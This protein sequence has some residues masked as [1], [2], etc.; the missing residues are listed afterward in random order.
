MKTVFQTVSEHKCMGCG[1]CAAVCHFGAIQMADNKDGF[2]N[3]VI[4]KSLCKECMKCFNI[5]PAQNPTYP[6][7][8]EPL[9]YAAMAKD[10]IRKISSS[11]GV[12]TVLAEFIINMDGYVCGAAFNDDFSVSHIIVNEIE[13]LDRL[14]GSKY[15]QSDTNNT[16]AKTKELLDQNKY[17]LYTGTPCQIAG[18]YAYLQHDYPHLFTVDLVC[19]GITSSKVFRKYHKDCHNGK[20]ITH[21]GFKE[22]E[23]WGW[24]AGMKLSFDDGSEYAAIAQ[25]DPFFNAYLK[26]LAKN[27]ACEFCTSNAIPRQADL[28]IGDFWGIR[29]ADPSLDDNKGTSVVLI[30]NEKGSELFNNVKDRFKLVRQVDLSYAIAGNHSLVKPYRVHKN[31]KWFFRRLE[32]EVFDKLENKCENSKYDVGIVGVWYGLNYGSI[33]TYYALNRI[34]EN[35]GYDCL[36]VN[37]PSMLWNDR[38]IDPNTIS[39]KFIGKYCNISEPTNNEEELKKINDMCDMFV[40]GSDVIWNYDICGKQSGHYFFLDFVDPEKKKIAYA[41]SFGTGYSAPPEHKEKTEFLLRSFDAISAREINGIEL[42]KSNFNITAEQVI[43]PVFLN[44][45]QDYEKLAET[46]NINDNAE[47]L[48]SYFLGPEIRKK[49]M[50]ELICSELGLEYRNLTNP[51]KPL[52]VQEGKL[53]LPLLR[54][55]TV[56]KWL[57]YFKNCKYYIGDSFHGMCFAIIFRKPF[58]VYV[59]KGAK[60]NCRFESLLNILGIKNR[61]VYIE[62]NETMKAG[63]LKLLNEPID[64]DEA[65]RR[66]EVEKGKSYNWLRDNLKA[67]KKQNYEYKQ[68]DGLPGNLI[69]IYYCAKT[70]FMNRKNRKVIMWGEHEPT[71]RILKKYFNIDVEFVVVRNKS[72]VN[73]TTFFDI[74]TIKGKQNEYYVVVPFNKYNEHDMQMFNNFGF[75]YISDV[76]YR[77]IKPIVLKDR[78]Y[79]NNSY[80][81]QFGNVIK[82]NLGNVNT[83][84]INGCNNK[85]IIHNKVNRP[86]SIFTVNV[87]SNCKINIGDN[88]SFSSKTNILLYGIA[89]SELVIENGIKSADLD[90]RIWSDVAKSSVLIREGCTFGS[91]NTLSCCAGKKLVVGKDCMFSYNIT[92]QCGDGHSIFDVTTGKNVNSIVENQLP[93]A[94]MLVLGE[95]VWIGRNAVIMHGSNIG[96]GSIVGAQSFVK[97]CFPNNCAIGG[98]PAKIVKKNIAWSRNNCSSNILDCGEKYI[99]ETADLPSLTGKNVLVLGGT[100]FMGIRLVEKLLRE[101]CYVTI[102]TRGIHK[103][104]FGDKVQ[105]MVVDRNN[106]EKMASLL[107]NKYYDV[108]FDNTAYNSNAVDHVLSNV[109]CG[110][111]IQ[112]SSSAVYSPACTTRYEELFDPFTASYELISECS[113]D[114]GKRYA[115]SILCQKFGDTNF[116]IVRV[117]AVL[118]CDVISKGNLSNRLL[119]YVE[120]II[121]EIPFDENDIRRICSLITTED[122]SE[123]LIHLAKKNISG[124]YNISSNGML[125]LAEIIEYIEQKTIKKAVMNKGSEKNPFPFGG[126]YMDSSKAQDTGY[127]FKNIREWVFPLID[128]YID[129]LT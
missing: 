58:I 33:L 97:G 1:A 34:I 119:F 25:K 85:I 65:Y 50:I 92:L 52:E 29:K 72:L 40:V 22:K 23:P 30:N 88:N 121:K 47:F 122:E 10:E 87:S 96:S 104:E 109:N 81:D 53:Q 108:I 129:L 73:N 31:S 75:R 103:D 64:F 84:I 5:C 89:G 86:N 46:A 63:T 18:L 11:G 4:N 61:I 117:P 90:I 93:K 44:S 125:T 67:E 83:V 120:H 94:N 124:I 78:D 107:K 98:N 111:Y 14:R 105:R 55:V 26:S 123:F 45:L 35:L 51:N 8:K 114:V 2:K 56:E 24:H 115:E 37:K 49:N 116:A 13:A 74:E 79:V 118:D 39:N 80:S 113:Y 127:K 95:H 70:A 48:T 41:P 82:G 69:D 42:L 126:Y 3:P 17:V 36:M 38:Y 68:P 59:L 102:A 71:R 21:I 20:K 27:E 128:K 9:C 7:S 66:L 28:T 54:D 91:N 32:N 100:G 12:F 106:K 101:K 76:A 62:D 19:H 77:F 99:N 16:Y 110:L 6:N 57:Y 43:D 60:D 112:V 15:M